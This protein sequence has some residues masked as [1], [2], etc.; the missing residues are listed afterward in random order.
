MADIQVDELYLDMQFKQTFDIFFLISLQW[1]GSQQAAVHW[2][3]LA[4]ASPLVLVKDLSI[5]KF[6]STR[7]KDIHL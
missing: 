3:M 2:Q 1:H 5:R 7:W 4:H 6:V